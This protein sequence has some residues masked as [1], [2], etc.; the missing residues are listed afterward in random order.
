MSKVVPDNWA[1]GHRVVGGLGLTPRASCLNPGEAA[2]AAERWMKEGTE[3]TCYDPRHRA[4][5][6]RP[7]LGAL[8]SHGDERGRDDKE[9]RQGT[10][11]QAEARD[12]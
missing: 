4:G 10:K 7:G 3:V 1:R 6:E 9:M 2:T 5:S 12:S 11:A 8:A